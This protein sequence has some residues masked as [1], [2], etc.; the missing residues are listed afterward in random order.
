MQIQKCVHGE[1]LSSN[2]HTIPGQGHI[3]HVMVT[4]NV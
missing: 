3:L 1:V 4:E 2:L